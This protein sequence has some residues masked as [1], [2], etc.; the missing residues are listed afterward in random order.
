MKGL[1]EIQTKGKTRYRGGGGKNGVEE[2]EEGV[3]LKRI[4][5][6]IVV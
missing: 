1:E 3:V 2:D 5:Y 6:I 4:N